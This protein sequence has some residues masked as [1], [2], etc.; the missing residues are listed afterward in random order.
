MANN[1][2]RLIDKAVDQSYKDMNIRN[3]MDQIVQID[4]MKRLL[5]NSD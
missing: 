4:K 5:L 1:R 2:N 3:M